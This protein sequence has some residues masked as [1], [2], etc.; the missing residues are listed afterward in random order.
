M[1]DPKDGG[2]VPPLDRT[3]TPED[4]DDSQELEDP[5]SGLANPLSNGPPAFMSAANGRTCKLSSH[6]GVRP[7]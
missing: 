5:E 1:L 2:S 6:R 7:N 3:A 4:Q